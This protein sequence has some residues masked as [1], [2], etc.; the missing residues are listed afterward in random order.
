MSTAEASPST[1]GPRYAPDDPNLP[2]PWKG[3][4][5]GSTGLQY[6]WN[7]ETNV[8]QYEKP[9]SLPPP[10]PP[11]LPPAASTPKMNPVPAARASQPDSIQV[12]QNQQ[13]MA[14]LPQDQ[15]MNSSLQQH[16][17]VASQA[18]APT[19]Q[20]QGSHLGPMQQGHSAPEQGRSQMMQQPGQQVPSQWGQ[21]SIQP[22]Q[23]G[24]P[25]SMQQISMQAGHQASYPPMQQTAHIQQS[26]M[27][28]GAQM[29]SPHGYQFTHQHTQYMAHQQNVPLQGPQRS[30]QQVPHKQEHKMEPGQRDNMDF[31][32]G[33]QP[34]FSPAHQHMMQGQQFPHPREQKAGIPQRDDVEFQPVNQAGFSPARTQQTVAPSMKNSTLGP[35]YSSAQK[36]IL[37]PSENTQYSLPSASMQQ[38]NP[39]VH[40]QQTGVELQRSQHGSR[41][42]NQL[43][44]GM[45]GQQQNLPPVGQHMAY[46]E[47]HPGRAGND[48]FYNTPKDVSG[49]P[50]QLPK[51]A[52]LPMTRNHQVNL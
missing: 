45:H 40:M 10:L 16:M 28:P 15:L 1:L 37:N 48:F 23:Q 32:Q 49:M 20:F 27:Y 29:A 34:G 35:N 14:Q 31:H 18:A 7:P 25:Q 44:P 33:K 50:P 12:P 26:Q 36:T 9:T 47:N 52:P 46:E 38:N 30:L 24:H 17:Q 4:I 3:L 22:G 5:D 19:G 43:G 51:L 39:S 41:F 21:M 42:Q 8:T 11:G 13:M 6:Y 2:E